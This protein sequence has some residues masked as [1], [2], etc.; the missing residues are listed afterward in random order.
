M[1]DGIKPEDVDLA[2]QRFPGPHLGNAR[3]GFLEG[4]RHERKKATPALAAAPELAEALRRLIVIASTDLSVD[5]NP[6]P[7]RVASVA[8]AC[9]ALAKARGGT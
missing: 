2:E 3:Y 7:Q 8:A 6:D 9:A 4:I 5:T 1:S